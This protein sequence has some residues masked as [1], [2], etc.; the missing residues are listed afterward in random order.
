MSVNRSFTC[1]NSVHQCANQQLWIFNERFQ[2]GLTCFRLQPLFVSITTNILGFS[3][4]KMLWF[5]F[6]K[7]EDLLFLTGNHNHKNVLVLDCLSGKTNK[8]ENIILT[9]GI[10]WFLLFSW[11]LKD[12]TTNWLNKKISASFSLKFFKLG[13]AVD[14]IRTAD[15][16]GLSRAGEIYI[17]A[18]GLCCFGCW[19]VKTLEFWRRPVRT[20]L[21]S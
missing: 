3:S 8:S 19:V 11:N 12:I 15:L 16:W 4:S 17:W 6:L 10:L 13:F 21:G 5:Q 18:G 2:K 9:T 7:C 20:D 1:G 14:E